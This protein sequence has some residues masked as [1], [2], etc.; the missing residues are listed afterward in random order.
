MHNFLLAASRAASQS[1]LEIEHI[2]IRP[3]MGLSE[4]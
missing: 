2:L 1:D 4:R 3:E